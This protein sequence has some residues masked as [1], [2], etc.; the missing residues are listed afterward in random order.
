ME[1]QFFLLQFLS[2]AG[3]G[4]ARLGLELAFQ[5]QFPAARLLF[6]LRLQL[7]YASFCLRLQLLL[8]AV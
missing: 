5:F 8:P 3:V 7:A 2:K 1:S 6:S 4:F